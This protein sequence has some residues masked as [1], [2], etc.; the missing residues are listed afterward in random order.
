MDRMR[1]GVTGHQ[2]LADP[3]GWD[4]VREQMDS[5]LSQIPAPLVGLTSLA[6]GA[7]Q[8]FAEAI[9]KC[10]GTLQAIIPFRDYALKFAEG[11]DRDGYTRLLAASAHVE[12]LRKHGSGRE[13]YLQAGKQV[14]NKSGLLVAVWDG[15]PAAGLGGTG[16]VVE[17]ARRCGKPIM[18]MNPAERLVRRLTSDGAQGQLEE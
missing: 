12:I 10:G 1:V 9:L 17:Y 11:P 5:V 4:W 18:H 7:D 15:R 6:L 13:A 3:V 2:R 16:D 8:R 14:V